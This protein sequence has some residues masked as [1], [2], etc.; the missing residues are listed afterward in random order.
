MVQISKRRSIA[1]LLFGVAIPVYSLP[2]IRTNTGI[3]PAI[4][5]REE[6]EEDAS[7]AIVP[8]GNF[9]ATTFASSSADKGYDYVI[10]GGGAAGCTIAN[11]LTEDPKISVLLIEAG[12]LDP[13]DPIIQIPGLAD[14]VVGTQYDWK[15]KTVPQTSVNNRILDVPMGKLIGGG[16]ALNRQVW[17]RA[18]RSDYDAWVD[19][20]NPGWGWDDLLPYFKKGETFYPPSP[21]LVND[22]G[23][24]YDPAVHGYTGPMKNTVPDY[25]KAET[26]PWITA[27]SQLNIGIQTDQAS[28]LNTNLFWTPAAIDPSNWTRQYARNAYYDPAVNRPNFHVLLNTTVTKL[29][30]TGTGPGIKV[31]RVEFATSKD[32]K[33]SYASINKEAI[34]TAGTIATPQILQASGVGPQALLNSLDI[35]VVANLPGVGQNYQ[36][37]NNILSIFVTPGIPATPLDPVAAL[38][39]YN[40]YRTGPFTTPSGNLLGFIPLVTMTTNTTSI[41][42][43]LGQQSAGQ[44]LDTTDPTVVAGYSAQKN[45][46]Q[47][48]LAQSD[49]AMTELIW[50]APG[51]IVEAN[52]H[53]FSRGSVKINSKSTFDYPNI[54]LRYGSNPLDWEVIADS[55]RFVRRV[56]QTPEM[57]SKGAFEVVPGPDVSTNDQ[58]TEYAK[59]GVSTLFHS[60]G[61][62]SMLPL[63]KG[64]VVDTNMKVYGFRNLRVCDAST[65]PLIPAAHIQATVYAMAEKAA[66]IIKAAQ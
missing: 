11:R 43:K 34:L 15:Y 54:D 25:Q 22:W 35:P 46:L 44:Y 14:Q 42:T 21:S 40:A 23:I 17:Q 2:S 41:L 10:I 45:V 61:T 53:P 59:S 30:T 49:I 37:H 20:G 65:I 62:A 32:G 26:T 5:A 3:R 28:G 9:T 7:T 8:E 48:R 50:A 27:F 19:L 4:I 31:T 39:E 6:F 33:R 55:H 38:A 1:A 47:T 24:S 63:D 60:S 51:I 29:I 56:M 66:D 52:Q 58:L 18:S 13:Y 16:T 64:G 12:P 36:D 57:A